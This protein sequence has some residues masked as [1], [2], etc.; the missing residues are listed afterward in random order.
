MLI[1]ISVNRYLVKRNSDYHKMVNNI[2]D[3]IEKTDKIVGEAY[4]YHNI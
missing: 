1:Q 3:G 4:G 2:N